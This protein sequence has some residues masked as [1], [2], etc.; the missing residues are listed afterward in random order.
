MSVPSTKL[1][2]IFFPIL[3]LSLSIFLMSFDYIKFALFAYNLKYFMRQV[4]NDLNW[5]ETTGLFAGVS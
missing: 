4:R 3:Q 2:T 5:T 1:C